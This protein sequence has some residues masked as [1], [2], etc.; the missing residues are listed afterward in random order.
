MSIG[1]LEIPESAIMSKRK[2][3][4][5]WLLA[6]FGRAKFVEVNTEGLHYRAFIWRGVVY[7]Y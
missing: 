6:K 2:L 3:R 4:L 5:F 1:M 7:F